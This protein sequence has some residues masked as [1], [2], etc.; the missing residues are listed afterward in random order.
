MKLNL[1][2]LT[3]SLFVLGACSTK[4]VKNES[5]SSGDVSKGIYINKLL[6]FKFELPD[7]YRLLNESEL[8]DIERNVRAATNAKDKFEQSSVDRTKQIFAFR[9]Y[10][11][12][13]ITTVMVNPTLLITTE[14]LDPRAKGISAK[15]Y[16]KIA[17]K[18]HRRNSIDPMDFEETATVKIG[19]Q[20]FE[21]QTITQ[22]MYGMEIKT[23][24]YCKMIDDYAVVF[25]LIYGIKE[26]R[27]KLINILGTY[28]KI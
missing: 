5:V 13:T 18:S 20:L 9:L 12:D 8:K 7:T 25:S 27:Q 28:E 23:G 6:G 26:D 4:P 24:Q 21:R 17:R 14:R 19:G 16:L 2:A 15:D 3:I 10:D 11:P 1:I 22:Q